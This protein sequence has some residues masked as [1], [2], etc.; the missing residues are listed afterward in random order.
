[1][2]K[3]D[4]IPMKNLTVSPKSTFHIVGKKNTSYSE[5]ILL[6]GVKNYTIIYLKSGQ[7]HAVAKSLKK[8]EKEFVPFSFFRVHKSYLINLKYVIKPRGEMKDT[9][10]MKNHQLVTVSRRKRDDFVKAIGWV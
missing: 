3:L 6:Q 8:F 1:M 5:V 9:I 7:V 2:P 4:L 10:E